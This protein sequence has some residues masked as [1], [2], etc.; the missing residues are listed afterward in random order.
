MKTFVRAKNE[1][2]K[3]LNDILLKN[4]NRPSDKLS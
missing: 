4:G 1:A 3:N 2:Y